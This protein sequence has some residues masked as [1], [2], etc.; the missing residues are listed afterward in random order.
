MSDLTGSWLTIN[1]AAGRVGRSRDTIERWIRADMLHPIRI[2]DAGR[3]RAVPRTA[4]NEAELIEAE[5]TARNANP[6]TPRPKPDDA[7]SFGQ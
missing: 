4:V 1:Q 6:A 5:W 3:G 7:V 2:S